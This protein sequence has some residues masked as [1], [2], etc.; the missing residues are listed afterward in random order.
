MLGQSSTSG[1]TKPVP[2]PPK[3]N[4]NAVGVQHKISNIND[5]SIPPHRTAANQPVEAKGSVKQWLLHY[6]FTLRNCLAICFF[7]YF[8]FII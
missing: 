2:I 8:L 3:K 6:R 7:L 5:E 1:A 4:K